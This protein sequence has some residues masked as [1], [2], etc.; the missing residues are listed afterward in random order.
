NTAT[1]SSRLTPLHVAVMAGHAE[2]VSLLL[3]SS[4]NIFLQDMLGRTALHYA[5]ERG[6]EGCAMALLSA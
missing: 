3:N 5:S 2:A 4:A 6:Y 1:S